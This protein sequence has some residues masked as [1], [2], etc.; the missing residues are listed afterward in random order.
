LIALVAGLCLAAQLCAAEQT[1]PVAAATSASI[2]LNGA[3][4][5][6]DW[7]HAQVVE[8]RQQSPQPGMPTP[9]RTELR[10]LRDSDHIYIGVVC[11][12]PRPNAIA[13]HTLR[14]DAE[15]TGDDH[16]TLVFDTFGDGRTAYVFQVN[17]AGARRDGLIA[18]GDEE[19]S[20][21]WDGLWN[22]ATQRNADGWSAEIELPSHMLHFSSQL[23]RW[24]FNAERY[25]ARER[26]TLRLGGIALNANLLDL[27]RGTTLAGIAGLQQGHGL[28]LTPYGLVEHH[29]AD[30][31][32]TR[33]GGE[34][35]Y[36]LTPALSGTLTA[37]TDFAEAE[38]DT[39][40]FNLTP[41]DLFRPEKRVFFSESSN[42]FTYSAGIDPETFIPFYSRRIGLTNGVPVPIDF[43]A[44]VV[45]HAGRYSIGMLGVAQ[46]AAQT[47]AP[48]DLAVARLAADVTPSL[49]LGALATS[50]D[51]TGV[52][53][54][55]FT[56][57]DGVWK[58]SSL[59]GDHNLLA[60]GWAAHTSTPGR[61]G[62]TSGYGIR[63]DFP[64]DRWDLN[65]NY[66]V[67]GDSFNP[68]LGFL[69]RPGTRQ[70]RTYLSFN[71]RP[72][73]G[74][75]DWARQ[76]FYEVSFREVDSLDGTP[77]TQRLFLAP[78]NV[79]TSSGEHVELNWIPEFERIAAPFEI[80]PGVIVPAGEYR[81]DRA[82][83]EINS[84]DARPWRVG[85]EVEWG[86]FYGG[87]LTSFA[88]YLSLSSL[89]GHLEIE[90]RH[91]TDRGD[92]PGGSFTQQ[93]WGLQLTCAF[94]PNVVF[95]SFDQYDTV[96]RQIGTNT[97]FRW[98][99]APG[100]DFFLVWN[101]GPTELPTD[102]AL[103][104]GP[105]E[106]FLIVKLRWTLQI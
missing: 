72:G 13:Q 87:N 86:A 35:R 44:K 57:V 70:F 105:A 79:R 93:L 56:G 31:S 53:D 97:V 78:F 85:S 34:L 104:T 28:T 60:S 30:G 32:R 66:N 17:A 20:S 43:G 42:L 74:A 2:T 62:M 19:L 38:A 81:F 101:R 59:L 95:T 88:P 58:T 23:D 84:A 45:G 50:G 10:V 41:F 96:S 29:S 98:T 73:P 36:D 82:R 37:N 80:A 89:D 65:L 49:R 75:F 77:Q 103:P 24:G 106:S 55:S 3:L 51:P 99:I 33:V 90:L 5:E 76:F 71:P 102:S 4:D 8:L 11:H 52:S 15:Q 39:R 94:T 83:F 14:R 12:D 61:T 63:A 92:L 46:S 67:F 48:T 16:V 54:N 7:R 40:Q 91:E 25:I 100:R 1:V 68:A 6:P 18:P 22:A 9:Y 69:P 64:N 27:R 21:D 26:L 47:A